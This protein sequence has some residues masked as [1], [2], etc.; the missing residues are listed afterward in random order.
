MFFFPMFLTLFTITSIIFLIKIASITSIVQINFLELIQLYSF[1]LPTMFFYTIPVSFFAS[2]VITLNNL[3]F[4]TEL[5]VLFSLGLS[6]NKIVKIIS[7][8]SLIVTL[9]LLV[10][11]LGLIPITKQMNKNFIFI[12]KQEANLNIKPTEFG[13]KFGEW[14]IFIDKDNGNNQFTNIVM[15]SDTA[16]EKESFLISKTANI[17]NVNGD[18]KLNLFNGKGFFL[19][20]LED[21]EKLTQINFKKMS[22]NDTTIS[23]SINYLN[24]ISYWKKQF[25][26][27]KGKRKFTESILISCFPLLSIFLILLFGIFNPRH[28]KNRS[29][30]YIIMATVIYYVLTYILANRIPFIAI[31]LLPVIWVTISYRF[32]K[33]IILERF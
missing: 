17:G 14:L 13:Q 6:P 16:L 33:K 5:I 20:N 2:A 28:Q 9:L 29:Y 32:Y 11:S 7:S 23:K 8:L 1:I 10:I 4:D 15:F 27:K 31:I 26:T 18:L 25:L 21:S 12:K 24:V 3:S 30:F 19:E 22:I